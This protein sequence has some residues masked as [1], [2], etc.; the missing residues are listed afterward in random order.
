MTVRV[1]FSCALCVLQWRNHTMSESRKLFNFLVCSILGIAME[2]GF[3]SSIVFFGQS[4]TCETIP[5]SLSKSF[6]H[7]SSVPSRYNPKNI[8]KDSSSDV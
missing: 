8:Q 4:N 5:H 1:T 7:F 3:K 2:K 6:S